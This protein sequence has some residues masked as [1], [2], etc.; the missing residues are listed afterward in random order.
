MLSNTWKLSGRPTYVVMIN[1]GMV[2]S[3]N[4]K[5]LI[6]LLSSFKSGVT[7]GGVHVKLDRLQVS[8]S[9]DFLC[10]LIKLSNH[11]PEPKAF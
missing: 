1:E 10:Q 7:H 5:Y 3:P 9:Y 2:T 8:Y 4:A 6:D 11:M